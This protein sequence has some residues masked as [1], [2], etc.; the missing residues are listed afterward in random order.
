MRELKRL[1]CATEHQIP[2]DPPPSRSHRTVVSLH[3]QPFVSRIRDTSTDR[4]IQMAH[5]RENQRIPL[6]S[7]R[8]CRNQCAAFPLCA[9][10][11]HNDEFSQ[12]RTKRCSHPTGL[13]FR[14]PSSKP[15]SR[16]ERKLLRQR[17]NRPACM[18][19]RKLPKIVGRVWKWRASTH[20]R[21]RKALVHRTNNQF[22]VRA[23]FARQS[24]PGSSHPDSPHIGR[25]YETLRNAAVATG[26][27]GMVRQPRLTALSES[28]QLSAGVA[29]QGHQRE[30]PRANSPSRCLSFAPSLNENLCALGLESE[31]HFRQ[32]SLAHRITQTSFV[33]GVEHE[34][35]AP[36]GAD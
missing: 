4:P 6:P 3:T 27:R 1:Y 9:F 2:Q 17:R 15:V 14:T 36:A 10:S 29:W 23:G 12:L 18:S 35:A 24:S 25:S 13:R 28:C 22:A 7:E 16:S 8:L 20:R 34:K 5:C 26:E 11:C 19:L 30:W 31:T 32:S 33:F 21:F